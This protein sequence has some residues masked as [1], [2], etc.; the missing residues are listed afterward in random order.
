[1]PQKLRPQLPVALQRRAGRWTTVSVLLLTLT[2]TA[3][4]EPSNATNCTGWS[5]IRPSSRDILTRET[6]E[7]IV[8]HFRYGHS[9][10]CPTFE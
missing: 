1:M 6:K 4:C 9:Q 3:A 10:R 5:A 8:A 2:L 7:Q